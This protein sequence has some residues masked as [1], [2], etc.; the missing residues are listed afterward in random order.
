MQ[1]GV[2]DALGRTIVTESVTLPAAGE[3]KIELDLS[4]QPAG[5]FV[6][7]LQTPRGVVTR[8]IVRTGGR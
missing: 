2:Y 7:K 3:Q 1:V 8:R 6:L 5:V 4:A